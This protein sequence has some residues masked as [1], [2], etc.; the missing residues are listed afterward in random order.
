MCNGA[1][2]RITL[3]QNVYR[4]SYFKFVIAHTQTHT[5]TIIHLWIFESEF[6]IEREKR[7]ISSHPHN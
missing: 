3:F 4:N 7:K 2:K 1:L 5:H 6:K